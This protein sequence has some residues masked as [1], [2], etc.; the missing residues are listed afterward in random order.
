MPHRNAKLSFYSRH[1]IIERLE[2]GWRQAEVAEAAGVSRCTVA[3]WAKRYREEGIA[4]LRDRSSKARRCRH[5]LGEDIIEAII[6]LRREL[7]AG[8]HAIAFRLGLAASTVYG[9][10]R[11]AGLSVLAR[12]D[13]TTRAIQ[14]YERER[15]GELVHLDIKR[16]G[17]IPDGGGKRFDPG[18]RETGAGKNRRAAGRRGHDFLHVAIDDHSRYAYVEA[19][20]DDKGVTAAAFL[21]RSVLAFAAV[22][23]SVERVLTDNGGCY[24]SQLF[25]KAALE[26]GVGRRYTR[27]RRP[28]TNGKAERF[29]RTLQAE[30][31]YQRPYSTNQERLDALPRFVTRYNQARPHT[32]IGNRPPVSRL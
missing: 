1:L 28:Q 31:A 17:K 13:R 18:W 3:K 10:L 32:A 12:L 30:W 19:L 21:M 6:R 16:L 2:R 5:A 26:L 9:V 25:A 15:P 23:V 29:I 24:R 22:G 8:P 20:P 7:G 11:R 4:G 27:P 14:R